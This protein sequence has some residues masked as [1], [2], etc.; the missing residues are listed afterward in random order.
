MTALPVLLVPSPARYHMR[1]WL[2]PFLPKVTVLSPAEI[3]P[4]IRVRSVGTIG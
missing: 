3:P 2:E 4:I 1:R